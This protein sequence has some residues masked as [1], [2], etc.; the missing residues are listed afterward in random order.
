[1]LTKLSPT[2][3]KIYEIYKKYW[4]NITYKKMSEYLWIQASAVFKHVQD[5]VDMWYL[6][7]RSDW[8]IVVLDVSATAKIPL[9]WEISCGTPLYVFEIYDEISV[10]KSLLK[11]GWR[12]YALQAKWDSMI[13]AGIVSWD[14]LIIRHQTDVEDW[15]IWVLIQKDDFDEYATLKQIFHTPSWVLAKP[16]NPLFETFILSNEEAEIRGKLMWVIR[17]Y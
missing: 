11:G 13:K 2:K 12:F 7:K 3:Q 9:L 6:Q 17:D 1:M 15:D 8:S 4:K 16:K 5:L 14:Y 10:P